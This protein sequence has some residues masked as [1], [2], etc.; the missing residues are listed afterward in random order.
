MRSA[1]HPAGDQTVGA[2][3]RPEWT[4]PTLMPDGAE[5]G[6]PV[7]RERRLLL[8]VLEDAIRTYQR[9]AF[10]HD[11]RGAALRA[12]VEEWFASEDS[13]WTFSFVAICDALGLETSYLRAGIGRLRERAETARRREASP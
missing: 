5:R 11:R 9:Y 13:D 12:Q 6:L 3:R 7:L 1:V 4:V 10:A 8:A 2:E